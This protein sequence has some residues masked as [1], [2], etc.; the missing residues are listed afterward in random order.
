MSHMC[1]AHACVHVHR[2]HGRLTRHLSASELP[3]AT[4][5]HALVCGWLTEAEKVEAAAGGGG[6]GGGG[7][8][9]DALAF[10]FEAT[11]QEASS[12]REMMKPV[13]PPPAAPPRAAPPPAPPP[14]STGAGS[15]LPF[16]WGDRRSTLPPD[17]PA[18]PLV[19]SCLLPGGCR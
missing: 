2:R 7:S 14:A 9:A 12:R 6:G 3:A 4:S 1:T 16:G 17:K 13:A 19:E 11:R 15:E 10:L 5:L 8:D 18:E